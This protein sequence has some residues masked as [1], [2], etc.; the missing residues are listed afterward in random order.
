M[1]RARR[2]IEGLGVS[3]LS[4][5]IKAGI[6]LLVTPFY[7][8]RLGPELMGFNSFIG[9]AMTYFQLMDAGVGTGL[10]AVVSRDLQPDAS[11]SE[12]ESIQRKLRAGGQVQMFF[13]LLSVIGSLVLASLIG[14]MVS[15]LPPEYLGMARVCTVLFGLAFA[16]YL[17]SG[18]YKAVLIGRQLI[19]HNTMLSTFAAILGAVVGVLLVGS[20]WL[21][22]GLAVASLVPAGFFFVQSRVRCRRLG[23]QIQPTRGPVEM[24]AAKEVI[25]LSAWILLA[26]F[27]GML[28]MSSARIILG[29]VSSQGMVAV[30]EY[31]LLLAAPIM[32]R[33][34]ANRIPAVVRPGLTQLAHS[35]SGTIRAPEIARLLVK[36][37]GL[38]GAAA[39][40][41]IHL[42]NGAFVKRWV[43][44]EYY[45][46]DLANTL[47]A[48]LIG[49]S[50]WLFGF[51]ALME[52]R[53]KY[54]DRSFAFL[55]AGLITAGLSITLAPSSGISGVLLAAIIGEVVAGA[56]WLIP[57]NFFWMLR[58]EGK[59]RRALSLI[60][61]PIVAVMVFASIKL[62]IPPVP[63]TWLW[64]I[65][66]PAVVV[67]LTFV[68]GLLWLRRDL[69]V[70]VRDLRS[71]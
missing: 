33:L 12:R 57:A 2:V 44:S 34:Q 8:S 40:S 4:F 32:I 51:K 5:P 26:S 20:G 45:A 28:S 23:V 62:V 47:A 11:D 48:I 58:P 50:I 36:V 16:L 49:L 7:L 15:G 68:P 38:T 71:A 61:F 46:G 22:Y 25:S 63:P 53:F 10:T 19:A 9:E 66:A 30:N 27:G 42:V 65:L 39:F 24:G 70:F 29:L 64:V 13:A 3:Y 60:W 56:I 35:E 37:A 1:S 54:K 17:S 18:V 43:G 52:V 14:S 59:F 21:L 6:R 31:A 69:M 41:V 67:C 55:A